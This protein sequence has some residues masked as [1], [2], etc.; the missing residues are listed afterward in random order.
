MVAAKL[1]IAF[2]VTPGNT[3]RRNHGAGIGLV[4]MREQKIDATLEQLGTLRSG[5]KRKPFGC[6]LP[7]PGESLA[8][9]FERNAQRLRK[10]AKR[11]VFGG[12]KCQSEREAGAV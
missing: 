5:R 2:F 7:L 4:F 10:R 6:P 11:V 8:R 1:I 9:L 3:E 12:T